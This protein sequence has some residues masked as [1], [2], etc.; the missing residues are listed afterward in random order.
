MEKKERRS[1]TMEQGL[2]KKKGEASLVRVRAREK[3][4]EG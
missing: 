1:S 4:N 2:T 3:R